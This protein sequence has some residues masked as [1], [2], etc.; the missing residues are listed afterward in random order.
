MSKGRYRNNGGAGTEP[1]RSMRVHIM[2][3]IQPE[4][5]FDEEQYIERMLLVRFRV[6][7]VFLHS[8]DPVTKKG[9]GGNYLIGV[10]HKLS[11]LKT[12]INRKVS[13]RGIVTVND[14]PEHYHS[15]SDRW[16]KKIIFRLTRLM[17]DRQINYMY[18]CYDL[19]PMESFNG[20]TMWEIRQSVADRLKRDKLE[21]SMTYDRQLLPKK[22][23]K[24]RYRDER[25]HHGK[26]SRQSR[27]RNREL[28]QAPG[29]S[30]GA[31]K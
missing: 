30:V 1:S 27:R 11:H 28:R 10:G 25:N 21:L 9:I 8:I 15:L 20:D 6:V 22:E 2:Y 31:S 5:I 16:R 18:D 13:Y 17:I 3:R 19:Y 24:P 29:I 7:S 12:F 26:P 14:L 23:E 4:D